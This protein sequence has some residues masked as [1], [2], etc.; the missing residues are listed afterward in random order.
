M[1][2]DTKPRKPYKKKWPEINLQPLC[3]FISEQHP[4]GMKIQNITRM[5]GWNKATVSYYFIKDDMNLS[6]CE[7]IARCYGHKLTLYY[8]Y[9]EYLPLHPETIK[10]NP[11]AG[12]LKGLI[13]YLSKKNISIFNMCN[14]MGKARSVLA[15]ALNTG[16][17]KI[18][19]LKMIERTLNITIYWEFEPIK[20]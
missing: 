12:N 3:N 14:R 7:E 15:N 2:E 10:D 17:I 9:D 5:T 20:N 4:D 19:T 16:D 13:T 8:P 18:S 11:N 1:K 6:K